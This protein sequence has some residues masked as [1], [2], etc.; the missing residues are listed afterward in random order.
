MNEQTVRIHLAEI[1]NDL[2]R[3]EAEHEVLLNL[4]K[5][6]EGWLRLNLSPN[7][8][9]QVDLA[10]P[11]LPIPT[12]SHESPTWRPSIRKVVKEA[13]GAPV[14]A[15]EIWAR[16]QAMGL[17]TRGKNPLG[18]VDLNIMSMPEIQKVGPRLY[19]W[20]GSNDD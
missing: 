10:Q 19:R 15:G 6:Y 8:H 16:V 5:G 9:A 4:L 1:R 11:L 2:E 20:V 17:K 12:M 13:R 18:L 3:N 7:G 14:H